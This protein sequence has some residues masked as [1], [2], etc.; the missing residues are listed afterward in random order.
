LGAATQG[1]ASNLPSISIGGGGAQLG[2]AGGGELAGAGAI[3]I[4]ASP[5]IATAIQAGG[6]LG[7]VG[8]SMANMDAADGGGDSL[9]RPGQRPSDAAQGQSTNTLIQK[10]SFMTSRLILSKTV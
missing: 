1:V 3:A 6:A 5:A 10:I 7:V 8:G 2:L 4:D 9:Q